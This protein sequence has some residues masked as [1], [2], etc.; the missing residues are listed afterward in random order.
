M[1]GG[2]LSVNVSPELDIVLRGPVEEVCVGV[3]SEPLLL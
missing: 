1:P 2:G 3:L